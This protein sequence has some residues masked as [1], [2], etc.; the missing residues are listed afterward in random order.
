MTY[1]E[2]KLEEFEEA[3]ELEL[4][5]DEKNEDMIR[6]IKF[7]IDICKGEING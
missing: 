2:K 3:L 5:M 1:W 4:A 7:E 6:L